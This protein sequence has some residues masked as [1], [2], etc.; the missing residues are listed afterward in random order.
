[1]DTGE[2]SRQ[3]GRRSAGIFMRN[4]NIIRLFLLGNVSLILLAVV[5][6]LYPMVASWTNARQLLSHQRQIYDVYTRFVV[7][8]DFHIASSDSRIL[9][10]EYLTSTMDE[11]YSLAKEYGLQA[12][13]F[14]SALW[15]D[16]VAQLGESFIGR[17]V[18]A[19]FIGD[20]YQA[21]G[22]IN[23]MADGP[24]FIRSLHMEFLEDGMTLL[25][26]EFSLFARE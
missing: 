22:F 16:H 18:S 3:K 13:I 8:D 25:R 1:M 5:F 9:S 24:A 12:T 17:N 6:W 23:K 15:T 14:D 4:G 2:A 20:L 21:T 26:V 19:V 11:I 7:Q 10:Y